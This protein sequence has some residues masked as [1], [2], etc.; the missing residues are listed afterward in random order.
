M[1]SESPRHW[2]AINQDD[3]YP[4]R[5]PPKALRLVEEIRASVEIPILFM[6]YY[7]PVLQYG[8]ERFV[9]ECRASGIDGLLVPDLP[10]EE[11]Q[12]LRLLAKSS[13]MNLIYLLSPNL[14]PSR[15][16]ATATVANGFVYL[17][18]SL[19]V[20]GERD[21]L[22][23]SIRESVERIR[24]MVTAPIC[25]GF[26]ISCPDQV[27]SLK[28]LGIDGIVVG[29]GIVLRQGEGLGS[30]RSFVMSLRQACQRG[31]AQ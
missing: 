21:G 20:T 31:K 9:S 6:T 10:I 30:V 2:T 23:P 14:P 15:I 28:S 19:G 24:E 22:G 13:G 25:V 12:E 18:S 5:Y 29:S 11:S 27:L 1:G 4:A 8:P 26:G 16:R 17:F 7:N 3:M